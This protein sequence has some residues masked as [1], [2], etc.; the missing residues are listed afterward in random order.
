MKKASN[1][2]EKTMALVIF[3]AG[4]LMIGVVLYANYIFFAYLFA[5]TA[6]FAVALFIL[7]LILGSWTSA[8]GIFLGLYVAFSPAMD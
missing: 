7:W 2:L 6:P 3:I 1:L 4:F 8:L 5:Q